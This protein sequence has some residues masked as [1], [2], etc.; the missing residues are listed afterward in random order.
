HDRTQSVLSNLVTL[1]VDGQSIDYDDVFGNRMRRT[2]LDTPFTELTI[3][4]TSRVEVRCLPLDPVR[5]RSTIP[6][7]WMPWQRHMLMP[8]LLP[9]EL[10]ETQLAELADYAMS[11]VVRNDGDL[12]DTVL[13]LNGSIYSQYK[14]QPGS[15]GLQTTAFDVYTE[16]RGVCQDFANLFICLARLLS[17]PARYVCGY[18]YTGDKKNT[19]MG[20]ASHAWVEVYLPQVGWRGFDPTNGSLAQSE[21]IRVAVGRSYVDATPTAGTIYVGGGSER[22]EVDVRVTQV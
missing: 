14:Y 18:V 1:S 4:A 9:T 21:H 10:P 6:L 3:Q 13:D 2:L 7:V 15:T 22:L 16:R 19:A 11:F 20:D 5:A 8:Y 17:I 12:L